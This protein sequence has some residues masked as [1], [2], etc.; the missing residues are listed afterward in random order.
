LRLAAAARVVPSGN[1]PM[2][3]AAPV[4][5]VTN[6]RRDMCHEFVI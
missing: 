5:P 2:D 4:V 6:L 1:S 3:T